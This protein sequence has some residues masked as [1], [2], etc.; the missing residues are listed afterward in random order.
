MADARSGVVL[1]MV[2]RPPITV[3]LM[4]ALT[5]LRVGSEMKRSV[6]T[7]T[8]GVDRCGRL[9]HSGAW[10]VAVIALWSLPVGD[11]VVVV[12]CC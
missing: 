8:A 3:G 4:S 1:V 12:T 9:G 5:F 11:D 6:V 10:H 7:S 2:V